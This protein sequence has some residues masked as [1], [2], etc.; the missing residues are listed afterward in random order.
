[1]APS[2]PVKWLKQKVKVIYLIIRRSLEI[3]LTEP[4]QRR[5]LP[6][7]IRSFRK[8]YLQE[9]EIPWMCYSAI[10]FLDKNTPPSAKV[11]EYGSGASTLFWL[12]KGATV[13][14][15]EH[16]GA[17]YDLM[18]RKLLGNPRVDYRLVEPTALDAAI[19]TSAADPDKY[20]S[21][22]KRYSRGEFS[23]YVSQIDQFPD[24]SF[25]IVVIDGRSRTACIKHASP[26]VK[27]GGILVLDNAEREWYLAETKGLLVGYSLQRF[28]GLIPTLHNDSDTNIYIKQA[29]NGAMPKSEIT[30]PWSPLE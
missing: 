13:V 10:D 5:Y 2:T 14:S 3:L 21:K 24:E 25:D 16:D 15:V 11:F 9:R 6:E 18:S 28:S 29:P 30:N 8:G 19:V 1:M 7:W 27:V 20:H 26:K 22:D 17:W 12:G 23:Q 4:S